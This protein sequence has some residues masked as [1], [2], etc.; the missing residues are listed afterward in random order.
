MQKLRS[1]EMLR[2]IAAVLVVSFH[3]PIILAIPLAALPF[4]ALIHSGYRGVDLFFVLSGFIIAHIHAADIGKPWRLGN[5][6]FNRIARI[7]PAVWSM[8][9]IAAILSAMGWGIVDVA[10]RPGI[11]NEAASVFLL[12]QTGDAIV[13]VTWSLKYELIFY[14]FFAGLI[15]DRWLGAAVLVLWQV[16]ILAVTLVSH[17]EAFGAA[18][19]YLR[20]ISLEFSIGLGCAWLI[21]QSRFIAVT[22]AAPVQWGFLALGVTAFVSG[23]A[24]DSHTHL[25][26]ASCALGAGG[27]I[28]GLVRLERS[29]RLGVPE[30]CVMLGGASYA[31]YLTH[32]SAITLLACMLAGPAPASMFAPAIASGIVAGIAFDR[33]I[34]RP[35]Q[36]LLRERLKPVLL[37]RPAEP[38]AI[39]PVQAHRDV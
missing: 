17:A 8:T 5:Y 32:Y 38:L 7:Y 20:S 31:I 35:L 37:G 24:R 19:F 13:N 16:T 30:W 21:G 1:L 11:W 18:A 33:I 14:L 25:T 9:L 4:P 29:G 27:V 6:A 23:M 26:D 36:R 39:H 34:D 15:L 12:P 3:T 22:K 28:V 10:V 2:A